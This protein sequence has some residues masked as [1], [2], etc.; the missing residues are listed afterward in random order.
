MKIVRENLPNTHITIT[1]KR[2]RSR[3]KTYYMEENSGA[4]NLISKLRQ[5]N[6]PSLK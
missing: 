6:Y 4:M 3:G 5:V 1:S 2:K